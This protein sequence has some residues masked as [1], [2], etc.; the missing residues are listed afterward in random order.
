[1]SE[2]NTDEYLLSASERDE[3]AAKGK[4]RGFWDWI[5]GNPGKLIFS[6]WYRI[7]GILVIIN[8]IFFVVYKVQPQDEGASA[9][10]WGLAVSLIVTAYC[11]ILP[12]VVYILI[13]VLH[14]F[15][16]KKHQK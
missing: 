6:C 8:I 2:H 14:Y 11:A 15:W 1:M 9:G 5:K 3:E 7:T 12:P 13:R 4:K 16:S 10:S